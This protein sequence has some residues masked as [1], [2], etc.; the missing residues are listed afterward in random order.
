M[1]LDRRFVLLPASFALAVAIIDQAVKWAVV[2]E[3]GPSAGRHERWLAGDWLGLSYAENS[4]VAFG[5][6]QGR[7]TLLLS[8]AA[9]ATMLVIGVVVWMHRASLPMLAA[10]GLI[11][12]GAMGNL[13]DRIRL[14][15]VRDFFAI[16]PWPPFNLADCA[17]TIGVLLAAWG[18]L[19]I[20]G[21]SRTA[22]GRNKRHEQRRRSILDMNE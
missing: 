9:A 15:H 21:D 14:G 20:E 18:V 10:G 7:S 17:I 3:V 16:G 11:V 2:R 5:L 1:S 19:R 4:G 13:I 6:L 8:F 22:D 12:G